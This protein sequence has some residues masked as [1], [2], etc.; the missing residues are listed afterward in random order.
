MIAR[1][2]AI[3]NDAENVLLPEQL[4]GFLYG[5]PGSLTGSYYEKTGIGMLLHGYGIGKRDNRSRIDENPI[6]AGRNLFHDAAERG[7]LQKLRGISPGLACR[8]EEPPGRMAESGGVD[9]SARHSVRP[10]TGLSLRLPLR[11]EL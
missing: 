8:K 5:L 3:E 4:N 9:S 1:F 2:H 7:S 10:A 6:K 11:E